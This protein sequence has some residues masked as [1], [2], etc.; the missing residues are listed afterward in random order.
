MHQANPIL[1]LLAHHGDALAAKFWA[2]VD[3]REEGVCWPWQGA[4]S[5]GYGMFSV[6]RTKMAAHRFAWAAANGRDPAPSQV[7]MHRCDNPP[8]CNPSH[9][10]PGTVAENVADCIAKG[11]SGLVKGSFTHCAKGHEYTGANTRPRSDGGRRCRTCY[12]AYR[13]NVR[14]ANKAAS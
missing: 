12:N 7:V 14:A 4:T 2:R 1:P 8:C 6:G 10:R 9:L 11:R 3:R 5:R 13:R